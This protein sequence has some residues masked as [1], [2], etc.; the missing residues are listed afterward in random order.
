MNA[1]MNN[2]MPV[3]SGE[4]E[5]VT[6]YVSDMLLGAEIRHVEEINR[7][8]EVT[9]VANAP[10]WVRGVVNLRGE[11]VTVLDLRQILG[12]GRTDID[13]NTRN[14][15]V[16]ADGERVGLLVNRIADVVKT[17]RNEIKPLPANLAAANEEYFGGIVELENELLA[18]LNVAEV[19]A[20][21]R[22]EV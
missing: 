15:V 6:F 10:Q 9:P 14:V 11:V 22:D 13:K 3:S 16:S 8:V 12:L 2:V 19:L 20:V 7:H 4:V 18:I 17:Q 1:V 5:F 21:T